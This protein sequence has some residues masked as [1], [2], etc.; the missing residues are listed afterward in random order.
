MENENFDT[1]NYRLE[2]IEQTLSDLKQVIVE[3]KLQARDIKDLSKRNN[4]L[5][6]AINSHDKRI[7][8]LEQKPTQEK[9]DRWQFIIDYIFKGIIVALATYFLAKLGLN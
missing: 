1:I 4:E 5:L 3:N 6:E 9:A 8:L 2:K 7:R